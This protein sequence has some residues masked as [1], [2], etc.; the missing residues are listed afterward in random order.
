M[1]SA[2]LIGKITRFGSEYKVLKNSIEDSYFVRDN[3]GNEF[4]LNQSA[5]LAEHVILKNAGKILK[6]AGL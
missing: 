2:K 6:S 3:Y 4:K 1:S 5:R